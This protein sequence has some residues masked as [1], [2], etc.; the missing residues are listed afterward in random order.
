MWRNYLIVSTLAI[1]SCS[2]MFVGGCENDAQTGALIGTAAG[3]GVGQAIGRN[4][5]GTLIGAAVGGFG[6]YVIGNESDKK[7][8]QQSQAAAVAQAQA[9]AQAAQDNVTV[10][11]T[12][13]NGSKTPVTLKKSGPSFIGPKNEVYPNMPTEDQ[14]KAVYGF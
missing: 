9:Q 3:A 14:L 13:S 8:A 2:T 7:K 11:V 1:I 6:G 12:N 10:W 4:T 5:A